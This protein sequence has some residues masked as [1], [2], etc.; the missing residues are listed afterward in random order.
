MTTWAKLVSHILNKPSNLP[1]GLRSAMEKSKFRQDAEGYALNHYSMLFNWTLL[2]QALEGMENKKLPL[3]LNCF[4]IQRDTERSILVLCIIHMRSSWLLKRSPFHAHATLSFSE[5]A[6]TPGEVSLKHLCDNNDGSN[7]KELSS[8]ARHC[9]K[10]FPGNNS[11]L[12]SPQPYEVSSHVLEAE[13]RGG[14]RRRVFSLNIHVN[15]TYYI[16]SLIL[17]SLHEPRKGSENF[18]CKETYL[19][20]SQHIPNLF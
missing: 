1:K 8:S 10:F 4:T 19:Y 15:A 12:S 7:S 9:V 5:G 14:M 18:F 17:H 6:G 11:F 20:S 16:L 2:S 13:F 3:H